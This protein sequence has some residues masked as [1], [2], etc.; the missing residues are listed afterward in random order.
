MGRNHCF[1]KTG[2]RVFSLLK[3]WSLSEVVLFLMALQCEVYLWLSNHSLSLS[4]VDSLVM[5][6]HASSVVYDE[7]ACEREEISAN[8]SLATL[9]AVYDAGIQHDPI[10]HDQGRG[11]GQE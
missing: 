10:P 9:L 11:Q 2:T 4:L 1:C 8:I 5:W 6:I 7:C 3:V